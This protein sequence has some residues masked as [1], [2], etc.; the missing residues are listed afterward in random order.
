[1]VAY[2]FYQSIEHSVKLP[3]LLYK[4]YL[5][6]YPLKSKQYLQGLDTHLLFCFLE[7]R[8]L[9]FVGISPRVRYFSW[10]HCLPISLLISRSVRINKWGKYVSKPVGHHSFCLFRGV[11]FLPVKEFLLVPVIPI[12][13]IRL[14]KAVFTARACTCELSTS[15]LSYR[16]NR[17]KST[18]V[19][20]SAPKRP[21]LYKMPSPASTK[22]IQR[23]S[24]N[25]ATSMQSVICLEFAMHSVVLR[26][27]SWRYFYLNYTV[28]TV[29]ARLWTNSLTSMTY[30]CS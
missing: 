3:L 16:R 28:H 9:W 2:I 6:Q 5:N 17:H 26:E 1:M 24:K 29:M 11:D 4:R 23:A 10:N 13:I 12:R 15:A 19:L 8:C 18:V 14:F 27:C 30:Y 25:V 7:I 22:A 20:L 21:S